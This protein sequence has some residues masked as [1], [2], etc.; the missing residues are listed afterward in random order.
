MQK[1]TF[2]HLITWLLIASPLWWAAGCYTSHQVAKVQDVQGYEIEVTTKGDITYTF[3]NW[4][5]DSSGTISGKAEKIDYYDPYLGRTTKNIEQPVT[6]HADSI[7][8]VRA[9]KLDAWT[10]GIG[11]IVVAVGLVVAVA[12]LEI[13]LVSRI[14]TSMK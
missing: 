1:I 2:N 11:I 8:A 9:T 5:S 12:I 10:T 13:V 4:R 3:S 7:V 6:I 14:L